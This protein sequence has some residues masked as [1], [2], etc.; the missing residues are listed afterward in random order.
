MAGALKFDA[1]R[2]L[3]NPCSERKVSAG[4]RDWLVWRR[5]HFDHGFDV[6]G[7][8]ETQ[9]SVGMLVMLGEASI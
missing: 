3:P 9:N 2:E 4:A 8:S 7:T 1:C 6:D 5:A